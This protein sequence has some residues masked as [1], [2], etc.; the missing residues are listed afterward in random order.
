MREDL[1]RVARQL[2]PE[3]TAEAHAALH[4]EKRSGDV[5]P[6]L[7]RVARCQAVAVWCLTSSPALAQTLV[8]PSDHRPLQEPPQPLCR[9][10]LV[11]PSAAQL[12]AD[13]ANDVDWAELAIPMRWGIAAVLAAA[14]RAAGISDPNPV[15]QPRRSLAS[16]SR[17]LSA[18]PDPTF[19]PSDMFGS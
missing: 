10:G 18:A 1:D 4:L 12:L 9:A 17:Q 16:S 2:W 6:G 8:T 5:A 3:L 7:A 19:G 13:F 15:E 14:T 11:Q